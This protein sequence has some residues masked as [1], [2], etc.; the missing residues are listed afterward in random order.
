MYVEA[1]G[2]GTVRTDSVLNSFRISLEDTINVM[3]DRLFIN[4][5]E[6]G[7]RINGTLEMSLKEALDIYESKEKIN[8]IQ[9]KK[10]EIDMKKNALDILN[11]TKK[12]ISII[13]DKCNKALEYLKKLENYYNKKNN[14]KV[15]SILKKL[16]NIDNVAK[17]NYENVDIAE[18]L[19][20]P[21]IYDT[22]TTYMSLENKSDEEKLEAI[23]FNNNKFYKLL[24]ERL[25]YADKYLADT[26]NKLES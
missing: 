18:S 10:Y 24:L 15:D 11:E 19:I 12:A 22:M 6:G 16:D 13:I 8:P 25:E 9:K 2:G 7:A 26:L 14:K 17:R 21:I 23:I 5:T 3:P 1:V 20:Y 4:A